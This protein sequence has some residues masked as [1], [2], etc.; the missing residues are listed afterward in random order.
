LNQYNGISK[1]GV[2]TGTWVVLGL[3]AAAYAAVYWAAVAGGHDAGWFWF[4][5]FTTLLAS[6]LVGVISYLGK[7]HAQRDEAAVLTP[8]VFFLPSV[9]PL[10]SVL[11]AQEDADLRFLGIGNLSMSN[12]AVYLYLALLASTVFFLMYLFRS[13]LHKSQPETPESFKD[14]EMEDTPGTFMSMTGVAADGEGEEHFDEKSPLSADNAKPSALTKVNSAAQSAYPV[15]VYW[16][17]VLYVVSHA[18][19]SLGS[20]Y[21]IVFT[22]EA[23]TI[24]AAFAYIVLII[25]CMAPIMLLVVSFW[26]VP[27]MRRDRRERATGPHKWVQCVDPVTQVQFYYNFGTGET[28]R[29]VPANWEP[30]T[31]SVEA[32]TWEERHGLHGLLG[33]LDASNMAVAFLPLY[34]MAVL[35]DAAMVV[36]FWNNDAHWTG[37]VMFGLHCFLTVYYACVQPLVDEEGNKAKW[38]NWAGLGSLVLMTIAILALAVDASTQHND[39]A[40]GAQWDGQDGWANVSAFWLTF[41]VFAALSVMLVPLALIYIYLVKKKKGKDVEGTPG[42]LVDDDDLGVPDVDYDMKVVANP[43]ARAT[44]H[45]AHSAMVLD[46]DEDVPIDVDD[47]EEGALDLMEA[48]VPV[49]AAAVPVAAAAA[50]KEKDKADLSN[51]HL[52][53]PCAHAFRTLRKET[54]EAGERTAESGHEDNFVAIDE[55]MEYLQNVP[56]H[57]YRPKGLK[58]FNEAQAKKVKTRAHKMDTDGNGTLNIAEF[59]AWWDSHD[60]D[61]ADEVSTDGGVEGCV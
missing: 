2:G 21:T 61:V 25:V 41:T 43:A 46:V 23:Q 31:D 51:V 3:L 52:T 19:L 49:A 38:Q 50:A 59:K 37:F 16:G 47:E 11:S 5:G 57:R 17:I 44:H 7:Y 29:E 8:I 48:G 15:A 27:N 9:D 36:A 39:Q 6:Q 60:N 4:C 42:K 34:L 20:L 24:L 30:R 26:A 18:G 10:F 58:E 13:W 35:V 40:N 28:T 45:Q 12:N 22:N 54:H 32:L 1:E 56:D 53:G 55:L 33:S 14:V